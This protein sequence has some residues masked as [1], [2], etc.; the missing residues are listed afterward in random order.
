MKIGFW[1]V[2]AIVLGAQ[3]GSGMLMLPAT[4]APFGL[5]SIWGWIIACCGAISL[6]S[7]FSKLCTIMPKTGG[8][9]AYVQMAFGKT[10]SFFTGWTYWLVSWISTAIVVISCV[11]YLSPFIEKYG[12]N[13]FLYGELILLT[14][15][16]YINCVSISLSGKIELVLTMLKF[17][18]LLIIPMLTVPYFNFDNFSVSKALEHLS[19]SQ[20]VSESSLLAF[21]GFIGVECATAPAGMVKNPGRNIP[22]AIMLG[23]IC[24]ALLYLFNCLG[25]MGAIHGDILSNANAPYVEF[26]KI[27]FPGCSDYI[28]GIIG[29]IICLG[30][31]NAWTLTSGQIALG[32]AQDKL[33]PFV[34]SKVNK[35]HAPYFN[36]IISSIGISI[37]LFLTK[38]TS[39]AKQVLQIIDFSVISFLFVYLISS[40]SFLKTIYKTRN[41]SQILLGIFSTGFCIWVISNSGLTSICI[42]SAFTL[43]GVVI[44][45]FVMRRDV[46]IELPNIS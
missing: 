12:E 45:P 36:I 1:S 19:T 20:I 39:I 22:L 26:A 25:I 10:A 7:V 32:L 9:H 33:L 13:A 18:P 11:A 37:I 2:F 5:L 27:A 3:V 4:L 29:F 28:M 40:I 42:A 21:W 14:I 8:P 30:T 17:A 35:S 34:F 15:I 23:T 41:M 46:S 16:T 44:Y 43:S 6:A 24:A 38:Q 31:L